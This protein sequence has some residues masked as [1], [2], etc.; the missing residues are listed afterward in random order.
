MNTSWFKS[1]FS[2]ADDS[3]STVRGLSWLWVATFCGC[4]IF[5][6]VFNAFEKRDSKLPSIDTAYIVITGLFLGAK[7]GQKIW[8]ENPS[9]IPL[10]K[11]KPSV[12]VELPPKA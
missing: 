10:T 6:T 12:V 5:C 11:T 8:G 9:G 7:V 4:I 1:F 2:G 3:V